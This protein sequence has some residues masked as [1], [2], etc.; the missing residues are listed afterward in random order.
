MG[1]IPRAQHAGLYHVMARSIAEERI[2]RV[3]EDFVDFV[4]ALALIE[5][6]CHAFCVMPTHYH[7]L[8][9]LE[10]NVLARAVHRLN[11]RYATRFNRRHGRRG[12]VFDGPYRS[13]PVESERHF[14]WLARYLAQNPPAPRSWQWSSFNRDFSFVDD[15]L[16]VEAFGGRGSLER[17]IFETLEPGSNQVREWPLGTGSRPR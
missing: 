13:V 9:T 5:W 14:V 7:V 8:A 1:A 6:E 10:E 12:H 3:P 11:R 15:G 4:N 17:Y 2:F 16:L